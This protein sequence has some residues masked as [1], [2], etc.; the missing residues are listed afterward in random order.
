[1]VLWCCGAVVLW[2]C[3]VLE[4]WMRVG[5]YEARFLEF[6]VKTRRWVSKWR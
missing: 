1:V 2:C 3:A 5:R 4:M 6:T